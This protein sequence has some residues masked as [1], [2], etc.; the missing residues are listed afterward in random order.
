M[1]VLT[2]IIRKVWAIGFAIVFVIGA[3]QHAHAQTIIYQDDFEGTVTG[4]SN[5]TTDF[6]PDVTRFLG[7]FAN[8]PTSTTQLFTFRRR[9][10]SQIRNVRLGGMEPFSDN[11]PR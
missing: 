8:N 3:S 11:G 7:R 1:Y 2:P 9:S 6:D 5:N 4:W 10:K